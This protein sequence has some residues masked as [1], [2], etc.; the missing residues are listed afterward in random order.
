MDVYCTISNGS[1]GVPSYSTSGSSGVDLQASVPD[2]VLIGPGER[3]LIPTGLSLAIPLGMEAQVRSRSGLALNHGV[4][5]LNSPGTIDSDYRGEV[6][7]ILMNHSDKTF[8]VK[9][10]MK[11]AQLVF[12]KVERINFVPWVVLGT[13]ERGA[14]GFGSTGL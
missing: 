10:G 13:T 6:K 14:N 8:T 5:V 4:V 3:K 12:S 11:V 2:N 9:P 7:V 1:Q